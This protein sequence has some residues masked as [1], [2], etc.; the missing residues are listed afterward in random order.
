MS[1]MSAATISRELGLVILGVSLSSLVVSIIAIYRE[2]KERVERAEMFELT[3]E[4]FY[5]FAISLFLFL[6][7][8]IDTTLAIYFINNADPG[9]VVGS[10]LDILNYIFITITFSLV[11]TPDIIRMMNYF[12]RSIDI[13]SYIGITFVIFL[14]GFA[15]T[16]LIIFL[17][18]EGAYQDFNIL[19]DSWEYVLYS[20]VLFRTYIVTI[21]LGCI[22]VNVICSKKV[23]S[24]LTSLNNSQNILV[25]R[26]NNLMLIHIDKYKKGDNQINKRNVIKNYTDFTFKNRIIILSQ[27]VL[28]VFLIVIMSINLG[29]IHF[30][31]D[32]YLYSLL[33]S[34]S[35][36]ALIVLGVKPIERINVESSLNDVDGGII[37]LS[38]RNDIENIVDI[39]KNRN[40][41]TKFINMLSI[42]DG[43]MGGIVP[44]IVLQSLTNRTGKEPHELFQF[45][46]GTGSGGLLVYLLAAL[47]VPINECLSII[48]EIYKSTFVENDNIGDPESLKPL[49]NLRLRKAL[50]KV[51]NRYNENVNI[52]TRLEELSSQD[53][54]F[55]TTTTGAEYDDTNM[56]AKWKLRNYDLYEVGGTNKCTLMDAMMATMV[57]RD[58]FEPISIE[59]IR[60]CSGAIGA[61]NPTA[62]MMSEFK[63]LTNKESG[64][65]SSIKLIVSLGTGR[66]SLSELM[67]LR[68]DEEYYK[69][70]VTD[71]EAVHTYMYYIW[72]SLEKY[73][74]INYSAPSRR[75]FSV[76]NANAFTQLGNQ[77]VAHPDIRQKIANISKILTSND[78]NESEE[79]AIDN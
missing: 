18:E 15:I 77:I 60:Y 73:H 19:I 65:I 21:Q 22:I 11:I 4:T 24:A 69:G 44:I 52:S 47:K 1:I 25:K 64:N 34:V 72:E 32:N 63:E 2:E 26:E 70:M 46:A 41:N 20:R 50:E 8:M 29:G 53:I 59:D 51:V 31:L 66:S 48:L 30:R 35:L 39:V 61:P 49:H 75:E 27:S 45:F 71:C 62:I 67:Q 10:L 68:N 40:P 9:I 14:F 43:G 6:L 76:R 16:M 7:I 55:F 58:L 12:G 13:L 57:D 37:P 3:T 5:K 33:F 42:D 74:R 28:L 56:D 78:V 23:S 54:L 36:I 79:I 38:I 17:E